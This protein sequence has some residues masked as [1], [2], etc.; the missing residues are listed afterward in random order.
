MKKLLSLIKDNKGFVLFIIFLFVFRGAI[1]DW[2]PVP[3]G[4][5]KPTILEGDV[6]WENKMAYDLQVP[7]TDISLLRTGEP[8]RG[9]IVVFTS[10]VANKRLIKRLVGLPGDIIKIQKNNLIING[11][12]VDYETT[13]EIIP[14]RETDQDHGIY[15]LES[16]T[17][18]EPHPVII[19]DRLSTYPPTFQGPQCIEVT[20]E[21]I[22]ADHYFFLGDNR[23]NSSDSRCIGYVPR[24]ELRGHATHILLS[25]NK[26][27]SY[28]PRLE[29][30]LE[31]LQ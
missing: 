27:D 5:M 7:F 31:K 23:D 4:S 15:A 1:A 19:K 22:P 9:D 10:E 13:D 21:A 11:Y 8:K 29:R 16:H 12:I 28:K 26:N 30:F 20:Q 25:L 14:S 17:D 18:L 24:S 6:I 3:T 2:H